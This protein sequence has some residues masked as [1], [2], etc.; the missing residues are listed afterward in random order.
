MNGGLLADARSARDAVWLLRELAQALPHA[1]S[2]VVALDNLAPRA[3]ARLRPLIAAL[4]SRASRT[5]K[6]SDELRERGDP[7]YVWG[8][9]LRGEASATLARACQLLADRLELEQSL[10]TTHDPGLL[11]YSLAFGRLGLL[12][13]VGVPMLQ[14]LEAAGEALD[15]SQVRDCFAKSGAAVTRGAALSE[16]LAGM[17][18]GLPPLT[19]DMIRDG[20]Q[21]GRLGETLSVVA[22]YLLDEATTPASRPRKQEVRHA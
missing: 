1:A 17:A 15:D 19:L 13:T 5:G 12:R 10:P 7:S 16:A 20:E 6:L 2:V 9:L 18:E 8:A 22:D 4:S 14:A 21:E 11:A 3:P